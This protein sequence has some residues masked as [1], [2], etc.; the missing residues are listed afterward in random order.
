MN[1]QIQASIPCQV[2]GKKINLAA[3]TVWGDKRIAARIGRETGI[4]IVETYRRNHFFFNAKSF[5]RII[6]GLF[7]LLGYRFN[8][9]MSEVELAKRLG[10]TDVTVRAS[11]RDWLETFPELFKDIVAKVSENALLRQFV[12]Y[13]MK[14]ANKSN[15]LTQ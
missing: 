15:T 12:Q 14:F 2:S 6:S 5:R 1:E 8:V 4:I 9:A 11:Y 10:T 7:F 3:K 13:S